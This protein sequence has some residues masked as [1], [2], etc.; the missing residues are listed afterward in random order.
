MCGQ[1]AA[2]R[3]AAAEALVTSARQATVV[4]QVAA[5]PEKVRA[6][7]LGDAAEGVSGAA[8]FRDHGKLAGILNYNMAK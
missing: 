8:G 5:A 1:G 3:G 4:E 7:Q 2:M 6:K